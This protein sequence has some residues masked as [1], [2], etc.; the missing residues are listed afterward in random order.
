MRHP[1]RKMV[2]GLAATVLLG[3]CVLC[4]VAPASP[5]LAAIRQLEEAP[6]QVVYQSRQTVQ[7]QQGDRWQVIWIF[8][9]MALMWNPSTRSRHELPVKAT[10]GNRAWASPMDFPF[11]SSCQ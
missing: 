11:P 8:W 9:W 2:A 7:D 4:A 10:S 1:I 3:F 6:A 5:A